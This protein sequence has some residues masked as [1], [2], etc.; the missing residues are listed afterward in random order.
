MRKYFLAAFL[1]AIPCGAYAADVVVSQSHTNFDVESVSVKAG[2]T[3]VFTNKDEINHNIQVMNGEGDAE[4][5]GMQKPGQNIRVTFAKPGEYNV[6]YSI[7]PKMK[8]T[9]TVQ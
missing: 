2:D 9:V 3:V 6:R 1:L 5:Y 7:H 4:D 8:L